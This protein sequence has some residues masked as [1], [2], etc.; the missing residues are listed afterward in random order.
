MTATGGFVT[1]LLRRQSGLIVSRIGGI[2]VECA[3][4]N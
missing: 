4:L 1:D 2:K 3:I